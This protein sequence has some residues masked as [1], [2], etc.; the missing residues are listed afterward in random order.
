MVRFCA[1]LGKCGY[2]YTGNEISDKDVLR[3]LIY[4]STAEMK[5]SMEKGQEE[6]REEDRRK[7]EKRTRR[8]EKKGQE[9]MRKEEMKN[10]IQTQ[11]PKVQSQEQRSQSTVAQRK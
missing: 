11:C 8:N 5:K 4:C 3:T 9:E 2:V 10:E 1:T 6:M 7:A